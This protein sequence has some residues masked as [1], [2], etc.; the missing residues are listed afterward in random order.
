MIDHYQS[1][2]YDG[3]GFTVVH[4]VY[5]TVMSSTSG[6]YMGQLLE[7]DLTSGEVSER[8]LPD[9]E[10]LQKTVGGYG[11]GLELLYDMIEPGRDPLD[12][13]NPMV[14]TTGPLTG[15]KDVPSPTNAT[16]TT[17]NGDT[18]YTAGRSH[19]H[20]WFGPRLK[21]AGYDGVILTGA[22][23]EWV[24]LV[25][26]DGD[27]ELRD[28]SDLLG[29]DTHETEDLLKEELGY[30]TQIPGEMSVAAIGPAGENLCD[31]ASIENDKNHAFSHSGVGQ[32]MGSKKLK[33]IA[34][35][36]TKE[37][38]V[39]DDELLGEAAD[40]WN[41]NLFESEIADGLSQ[42]G[43]PNSEYGFIKEASLTT[44]KNML[45]V[46]DIDHEWGQGMADHDITPKPCFACPIACS[47]DYEYV[48]GDNE[49]YLAT[50]AGGGENL[51][52]SASIVGVYDS[53]WIHYLT[54]QCDRLGFESS[55]IGATIAVLMEAFDEGLIDEEDTGGIT[56]EWGDPELVERLLEMAAHREGELGEVL[57]E[58][59][60]YAAEW[61]GNDMIDRSVHVKG[62]GM[63]LHDWR[64]AWGINLGQI[65]G[66]S[67]SWPAPA[68]DAWTPPIDAGYDEFQDPFDWE[69]KPK[70]VT[71]T[72]PVKYWD[73]ANGTCWFAT[74][75]VPDQVDISAKAVAGVTG[76]DFDGEDAR[77]VGE[78]LVHF[79]RAFGARFGHTIEDDLNVPNRIVEE[80][81][82]GLGAGHE[83]KEHLEWMVHEVYRRFGWDEQTGKPL[84]STLEDADLEHVAEDLWAAPAA[85]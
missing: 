38:P 48:H 31:G 13:E 66:P 27:V 69:Q 32:I 83:M 18:G 85:D 37:I 73:D 9:E 22:S 40:E 46:P 56:L 41:D 49:G 42:G 59:P 11:L 55:G 44:A 12:P 7:V 6:G 71:D 81:P 74:W 57:A 16:I 76:W 63:N 17:L 25:I 53:D 52:G 2:Q 58:G 36:G 33:A 15:I 51:E 5:L 21:F 70:E 8:D 47:Y 39:A 65:V 43:V 30:P 50:I 3:S 26:D 1:P 35:R 10:T 61:A 4:I 62:S 29:A 80:P 45:E 67:A 23:D 24:S 34:V 77:D 19:S 79:E 72:W 20:G 14:L 82:E 68:A 54:D 78:R 60:G 64:A 28:A 84:R 75:G